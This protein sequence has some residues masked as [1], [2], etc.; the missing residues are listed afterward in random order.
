MR[1]AKV[2][3][4]SVFVY[5]V[6]LIYVFMFNNGDSYFNIN[7]YR[8][9]L[10]LA[11]IVG[12][13]TVLPGC[14]RLKKGKGHTGLL[15]LS[16]IVYIVFSKYILG[17]PAEPYYVLF[18]SVLYLYL[19]CMAKISFSKRDLALLIKAY[20]VSSV[21]MS[22]LV[23]LFGRTPYSAYGIF[24]RALYYGN[25]EYYDVNFTSMYLLTP[26]LFSFHISMRSIGNKRIGYGA[27]TAIN[28]LAIMLMGSRATFIPALGIILFEIFRSKK[29]S[30]FKIIILMGMLF[31]S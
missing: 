1:E 5:L 28:M 19:F 2:S 21:I 9:A 29:V 14:T 31:S 8:N 3:L 27:V 24:R 12:L 30:L 10:F 4:K 7:E 26:T 11:V 18:I 25:N 13:L 23:L 22:V 20:I 16:C 15:I 6:G 17:L